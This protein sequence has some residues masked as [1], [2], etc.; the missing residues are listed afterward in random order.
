MAANQ[1]AYTT[2]AAH[3]D[4]LRRRPV[5]GQDGSNGNARRSYDEIDDKKTRKVAQSLF[6]RLQ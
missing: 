4:H 1:N 2:G 5:P 3:E 6:Q